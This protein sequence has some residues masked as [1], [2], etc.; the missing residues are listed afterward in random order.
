VSDRRA[1][2]ALFP[3]TLL[4]DPLLKDVLL[5]SDLIGIA[6]SFGT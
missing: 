4:S 6:A 1:K 3:L 2:Q 5:S